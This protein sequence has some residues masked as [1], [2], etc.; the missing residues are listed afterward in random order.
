MQP[1]SGSLNGRLSLAVIQS[2]EKPPVDEIKVTSEQSNKD[3]ATAVTETS[4]TVS[5]EVTSKET[6]DLRSLFTP[7]SKKSCDNANKQLAGEA[8]E[9]KSL[10]TDTN[11]RVKNIEKLVSVSTPQ[12]KKNL[13]SEIDRLKRENK[14]LKQGSTRSSRKG[15]K[16]ALDNV[17]GSRTHI[18]QKSK[19]N[20]ENASN[21]RR[22]NVNNR[23]RMNTK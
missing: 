8:A 23:G 5:E 10:A 18:S 21:A 6:G 9:M 4:S 22:K 16:A 12:A 1:E 13:L 14:M 11:F 15:D 7:N 3:D 17:K 20:T 19:E 2:N